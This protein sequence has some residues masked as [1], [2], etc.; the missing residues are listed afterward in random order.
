MYQIFVVSDGTGGT[1]DQLLRAALAQFKEL[2]VN[3]QRRG[4]IL[5]EAQV[6]AVVKEAKDAQGF[7]V[8]TVVSA[9]MRK[10]IADIGRLHGVETIDLMGPLLAQL[11][12]QFSLS[13]AEQPGLFR[14]LNREYFQR[15][16][17]MEFAFRHDDGQRAREL[18]KADIVLVGVSRTFKTPLSI[19]FAFKGWLVG[20]VPIISD[21]VPPPSIFDLPPGKVFCLT[22]QAKHLAVLRGVRD[23]HLGGATGT[24]ADVDFIRKELAYANSVFRKGRGWDIID[25]TQK[26]IEEIASDILKRKRRR[27][28]S[29][30]D[31]ADIQQI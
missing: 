5:S 22:T 13:P 19:Y 10:V 9:E 11:T 16:E 4:G 29:N 17:A 25:V 3:I 6:I 7:I 31:S 14:K 23:R 8:H 21:L 24:Y 28:E 15:I 1:A 18:D 20:N 26:P 27:N 2:D 30:M 12:F